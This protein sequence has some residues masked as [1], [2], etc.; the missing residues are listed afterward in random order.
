MK[1]IMGHSP[2]GDDN[3]NLITNVEIVFKKTSIWIWILKMTEIDWM[4]KV[5]IILTDFEIT[6]SKIPPRSYLCIW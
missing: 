2:A 3:V 6:E 4:E 1:T 5:K